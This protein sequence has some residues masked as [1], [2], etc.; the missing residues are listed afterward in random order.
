MKY[1]VSYVVYEW[2]GTETR[3]SCSDAK[4]SPRDDATRRCSTWDEADVIRLQ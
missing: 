3:L 2:E 4:M 1:E